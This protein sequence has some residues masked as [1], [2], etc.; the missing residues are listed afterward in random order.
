MRSVGV[1]RQK[2]TDVRALLM[3]GL[4]DGDLRVQLA[5]V[6][7]AGQVDGSP[8]EVRS[9]LAKSLASADAEVKAS[10]VVSALR[11]GAGDVAVRLVA[12]DLLSSGG[13]TACKF[14]LDA[15]AATDDP[16]VLCG[17]MVPMLVE[18][19]LLQLGLLDSEPTRPCWLALE[20]ALLKPVSIPC[21]LTMQMKMTRGHSAV[22]LGLLRWAAGERG[23][24]EVWALRNGVL[25][26]EQQPLVAALRLIEQELDKG[27]GLPSGIEEA[28]VGAVESGPNPYLSARVLLRLGAVGEAGFARILGRVGQQTR[29]A[30][31]R[32]LEE[33]GASATFAASVETV[34][35]GLPED[36][37]ASEMFSRTPVR[38]K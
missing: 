26:H 38:Q 34:L 35:S 7:A 1:R 2:L 36:R 5:A 25:E 28:L 31:L 37:V 24:Q 15:F 11:A 30:M 4:V 21:G 22:A 23:E 20:A 19:S 32:A 9:L 12:N 10:A 33:A 27:F 17:L 29:W 14:F 13:P 8:A 3:E 16:D 6:R 18:E